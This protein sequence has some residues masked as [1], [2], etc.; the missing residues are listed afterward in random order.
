MQTTGKKT[1]PNQK[2]NIKN[3]NHKAAVSLLLYCCLEIGE[4]ISLHQQIWVPQCSS[5]SWQGTEEGMETRLHRS[6]GSH[7]RVAKHFREQLTAAQAKQRDLY[8]HLPPHFLAAIS[9]IQENY[10]FIHPYPFHFQNDAFLSLQM[11]RNIYISIIPTLL[12]ERSFFHP[13]FL[14]R[15]CIPPQPSLPCSSG[16]QAVSC[17]DGQ[18]FS[19]GIPPC[20]EVKGGEEGQEHK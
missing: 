10:I 5:K 9:V 11:R 14:H 17:G 3:Q 12:P 6:S 15:V 19:S 2:S 8:L 4:N 18:W 13:Y 7:Q 16:Q 20:E 1:N